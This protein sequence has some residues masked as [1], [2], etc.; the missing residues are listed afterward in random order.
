MDA[1]FVPARWAQK[2]VKR[3][4]NAITRW[5]QICHEGQR[6]QIAWGHRS[7]E[8]AA[9]ERSHNVNHQFQE[10][11]ITWQDLDFELLIGYRGKQEP[12]WCEIT[13]FFDLDRDAFL[14]TEPRTL[15]NALQ[16]L[17]SGISLCID[18]EDDQIAVV[19]VR[20]VLFPER[21]NGRVLHATLIHLA[22]S[23]DLVFNWLCLGRGD[24]YWTMHG[25]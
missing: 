7:Q 25:D 5:N 21:I 23:R 9:R 24:D 19:G 14:P 8:E 16:C 10:G 3:I 13:I 17:D 11:L 22:I 6:I 12:T 20:T 2:A 4:G 18:R 1:D 15:Y